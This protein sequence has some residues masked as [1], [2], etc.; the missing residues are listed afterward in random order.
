MVRKIERIQGK[1]NEANLVIINVGSEEKRQS[2][3][4]RSCENRKK[5]QNIKL[6]GNRNGEISVEN[7]TQEII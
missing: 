2:H 6:R 1:Q 4:Q 3:N 7:E 5:T